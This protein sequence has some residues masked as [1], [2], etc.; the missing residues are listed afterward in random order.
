MAAHDLEAHSPV[1]GLAS[2]SEWR[3]MTWKNHHQHRFRQ[4]REAPVSMTDEDLEALISQT[5]NL[6]AMLLVAKPI[7]NKSC[8]W[9]P[10]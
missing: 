3:A 6:Q 8:T 2:S 4:L 5:N 10:S 1:Q 9:L 7:T